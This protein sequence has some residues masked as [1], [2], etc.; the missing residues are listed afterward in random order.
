MPEKNLKSGNKR[1][2]GLNSYSFLL[3]KCVATEWFQIQEVVG[4]IVDI[5]W[6][7]AKFYCFL[8]KQKTE[9]KNKVEVMLF[10]I[11][12]TS[13]VLTYQIFGTFPLY[14][15]ACHPFDLDIL[16]VSCDEGVMI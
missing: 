16:Y 7:A 2:T 3:E 15:L 10:V 12:V 11:L 14:T 6:Y 5:G 13:I 4:D 1:L 9:L 8:A